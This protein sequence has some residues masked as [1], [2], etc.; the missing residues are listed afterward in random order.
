MI[1]SLLSFH[2]YII[3]V[4]ITSSFSFPR[5]IFAVVAASSF[6]FPRYL[7]PVATF[8]FHQCI[9]ALVAASFSFLG[10]IFIAVVLFSTDSDLTDA[11][12]PDLTKLLNFKLQRLVTS[13]INQLLLT[14]HSHG[15]SPHKFL[16]AYACAGTTVF[17]FIYTICYQ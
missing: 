9:I 5:D 11:R 7:V 12:C 3:E 17:T 2:R 1:S 13:S 10:Y 4:A 16:T 8:S 14:S 15:L 6:L